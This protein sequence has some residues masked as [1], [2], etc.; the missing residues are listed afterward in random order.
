MERGGEVGRNN[1][2]NKK[3]FYSPPGPTTQSHVRGDFPAF[4]EDRRIDGLARGRWVCV[5]GDIGS[6]GK[7]RHH[8]LWPQNSVSRQQ[9]QRQAE[10]SSECGA[11]TGKGREFGVAR[12]IGRAIGR[13]PS[14]L[15]P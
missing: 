9:R 12:A 1:T 14:L 13:A 8:R 6:R 3:N 4:G 15:V 7:F 2:L 11:A 5:S 10:T